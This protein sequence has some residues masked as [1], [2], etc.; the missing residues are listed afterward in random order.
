MIKVFQTVVDKDKGNCMQAAIASMFE[1]DLSQV[2]NFIL[3]E[4]TKW[5]DALYHFLRGLGYEFKGTMRKGRPI[6]DDDLINGCV[7]AYVDSRTC[8]DATHAVLVN[9]EGVV[10]HDPNP[11]ERWLGDNALT[12]SEARGWWSIEKME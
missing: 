6:T 2:P 12:S 11:N 1:L 9:A 7:Y 4:Q 10:I 3:F 8:K 5:F